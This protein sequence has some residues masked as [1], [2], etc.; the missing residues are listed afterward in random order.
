MATAA[1]FSAIETTIVHQVKAIVSSEDSATIEWAIK[2]ITDGGTA[3][4]EGSLMS[5]R[6]YRR[7]RAGPFRA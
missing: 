3:T 6:F 2:T 4:K 1:N 5:L 7:F